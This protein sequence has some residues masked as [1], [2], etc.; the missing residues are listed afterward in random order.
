MRRHAYTPARGDLVWMDVSPQAGHEQGG[1]RPA[2]VVT[3]SSYNSKVG[4]ALVCPV[5]SQMKGYPF[6]V[7]I[8][9][10]VVLA[11]HVRSID[12]RVRKVAFISKTPRDVVEGVLGRMHALLGDEPR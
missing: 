9:G 7:A 4:F 8:K 11:D 1:R 3:P 5:T 6:E 10:G 12:W 2:L